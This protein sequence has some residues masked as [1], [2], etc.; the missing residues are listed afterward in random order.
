[1]TYSSANLDLGDGHQQESFGAIK[2]SILDDDRKDFVAHPSTS[3]RSLLGFW[4][5][6]ASQSSI[7]LSSQPMALGP[8][9]E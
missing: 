6:P 3:A 7:S 4:V 2:R 5:R 1:M 8:P 9:S